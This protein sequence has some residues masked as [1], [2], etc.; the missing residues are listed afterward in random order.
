MLSIHTPSSQMVRNSKVRSCQ[1]WSSWM[2]ESIGGLRCFCHICLLTNI[3]VKSI[4]QHTIPPR[5]SWIVLLW[6]NSQF[7]RFLIL[8]LSPSSFFL[9]VPQ[10]SVKLLFLSG[11]HV[12]R[13]GSISHQKV[14]IKTG[15]VLQ[16]FSHPYRTKASISMTGM[17]FKQAINLTYTATNQL[18]TSPLRLR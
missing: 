7:Q 16:S 11:A 8:L 13:T 1:I 12:L 15:K 17:T 18:L 14:I 3:H 5:A 2:E 6:L 4:Y 9:C 10:A